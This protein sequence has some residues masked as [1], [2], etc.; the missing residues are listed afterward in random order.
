MHGGGGAADAVSKFP[1][2][3]SFVLR[4]TGNALSIDGW[5]NKWLSTGI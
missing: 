2:R 1:F 4:R 5:W 3:L